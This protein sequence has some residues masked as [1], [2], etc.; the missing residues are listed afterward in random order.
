MLLTILKQVL[1]CLLGIAAV[2][3]G[4]LLFV[5]VVDFEVQKQ[6]RIWGSSPGLSQLLYILLVAV[7]LGAVW[8][9]HGLWEDWHSEMGP[10]FYTGA[11]AAEADGCVVIRPW[12][13]I[14]GGQEHWEAFLQQ[15]E[16][17]KPASVRLA[18]LDGGVISQIH[19]ITCD[20]LMFHCTK[21]TRYLHRETETESYAFLLK[22]PD[23][24]GG[25]EYTSWV[26]TDTPDLTGEAL[27]R[28]RL[29]RENKIRAEVLVRKVLSEP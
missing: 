15:V 24:W 19:E 21:H 22:I 12:R 29:E 13:E 28:D 20:G 14:D 26:L 8:F 25:Y 16:E 11:E 23:T 4:F 7:I 1:I 10:P 6:K 27:H 5:G 3:V 9:V 17:R 2:V 18:L